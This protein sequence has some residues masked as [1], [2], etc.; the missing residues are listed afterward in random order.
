MIKLIYILV[1][2]FFA[3]ASGQVI[4]HFKEKI[5]LSENGKTEVNWEIEYINESH[6]ERLL[7]PWN[8]NDAKLSDEIEYSYEK[9]KGKE[10]KGELVNINSNYFVS[11]H[12]DSTQTRLKL[13]IEFE[14]EDFFNIS[15]QKKKDFGNYSIK[16][17]FANSCVARIKKYES[18]IFLPEKYLVSAVTESLPEQKSEES[19]PP[20]KLFRENGKNGIKLTAEEVKL[21]G[22]TLL[23]FKFK[24]E[25]KSNIFLIILIVSGIL[26]LV[27]FRDILKSGKK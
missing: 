2:V 4:N 20:Y 21:G 25:E 14:I 22:N 6:A 8:F 27:F 10:L 5:Y 1:M 15:E 12:L 3:S 23:E 18:S 7:L 11:V 26:Y 24:S 13:E 17:V 9:D 16:V 19:I